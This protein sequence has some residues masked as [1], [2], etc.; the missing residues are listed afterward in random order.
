MLIVDVWILAC[1]ST[2]T[3]CFF[4]RRTLISGIRLDLSTEKVTSLGQ[5][6]NAVSALSYAREI[7]VSLLNLLFSFASLLTV[8]C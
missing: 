4:L 6:A 5:H 2:Y 7:S 8:T 1:V 3:N